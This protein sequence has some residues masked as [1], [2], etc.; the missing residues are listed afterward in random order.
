MKNDTITIGILAHVD[1]GKT[2]LSEGLLYL[3]GAIRKQGRVDNKDS[4]LDTD[5][6]ER[7]H[8]ITI[9]SKQALFSTR[10]LLP[11]GEER[12]RTYTLL[13]TPGH[14]DFSAEMERTL[15]VLDY[16][17][18]VVSAP[19]GVTG[20]VRTLWKLLDHYRVPALIFV[21]KMD[22]L[23][24][25]GELAQAAA[26]GWPEE[27]R[28]R[29]LSAFSD[30]LGGHFADFTGDVEGEEVQEEIALCQES[31]MEQFLEG[32]LISES[33]IADL[34]REKALCPVLFGSALK[35]LGVESLI[36]A[37]D[38]FFVMPAWPRQFGARVFKITRDEKGERLTWMKITGGSLRVKT[39]LDLEKNG[40]VVQEKADQIRIYNG[41]RFRPDQE[42]MAGQVC[43]VTGLTATFA[44]QG[45]GLETGSME[46]LLQPVLSCQILL[47]PSE[48]KFKAYRNLCL[49]EE[50]DPVLHVLYDENKKEITA[51]VMGE[52]QREVLK[53]LAW[54]RFHLSISFG[55]PGIVYKETI[56][57]A[58]E[59]VGHFEPLRHYAEVHLLLEPGEPG[60]G[61]VF[62]SACSVNDLARNWQ[63]LVLTHLRERRHKGVLT[64]SEITDMK[65]TLIG[66]RA[67]EKHTEGGDFRQ[68]TYRAVRQ[69]LMM[70]QSALLEPYYSFRLE[71][72][73]DN[74][75]HA[76]TD[77]QLMGA[78][79]GQPDFAGDRAI[80]EGTVPVSSLGEYAANLSA[81]T[82]GEGV[83][84]CS[85]LGYGPCH[86]EEEVIASIGY[87]PEEDL[88]NP[89]SSVFCSHGA[90]VIIPWYEVRDYMQVDTGWRGEETGPVPEE[91]TM[92]A[93]FS[94]VTG[95]RVRVRDD[96]SFKERARAAAAGE[97]ELRAIFERTYGP[98]RSGTGE[99]EER[100]A[101]VIAAPGTT[102]KYR[103]PRPQPEKEYLLVDGYNIIYA[104]PDLR[105]LAERD[106]KAARDTL[107]DILSNF[108]GFRREHVILVFD[109][110]KVPGG[111]TRIYRYHNIDVV[112]TKE[113]ETADLYIEKTTHELIRQYKV[114]VATS[115]AVEQV[116]IF[117][118]G[119][120]RMSASML[121][122]EVELTGRQ[123]RE[124]YVDRPE[125]GKSYLLDGVSEDILRQL[126]EGEE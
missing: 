49:L 37:M 114:T 42:A 110:Y 47:P 69:G 100:R 105:D 79:F 16:A 44:G 26:A 31:L 34:I 95:R 11:D 84:S 55:Q 98:I 121:L 4:F 3:G 14:A 1:A 102:P 91:D 8:G 20:Q 45:L 9:F 15:Q 90:G 65:I 126:R 92:D 56:R 109:A 68:A 117:G 101:R 7:D 25:A 74:L 29:L 76:L 63:R 12:E 40:E 50:E 125:P 30:Q 107:M 112:F 27:E 5:Q 59:G 24:P 53:N 38:R 89:S 97:D 46:G 78:S 120:F 88:R 66:G 43:A 58:A 111:Q 28:K 80:L 36:N 35:N 123:I 103:R 6:M 13:D 62:D 57:T 19:D 122:E 104:W 115:D 52:M 18:L 77:L 71:V 96:R 51:Q 2:T 60:S 108:A 17:I 64:G 10:T 61:L 83:L 85:L 106:V 116:I 93:G 113:A 33:Q 75:G 41:T 70:A 94:A 119:A 81:Y 82:K 86:N 73:G 54:E 32:E 124:G 118:A 23:V 22:Q 99:G 48:D 72:P 39:L 87:D 67:H 21:N